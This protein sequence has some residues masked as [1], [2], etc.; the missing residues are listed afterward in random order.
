MERKKEID[1][2]VF[3]YSPAY[4]R[5]DSCCRCNLCVIIVKSTDGDDDEEE[6]EEDDKKRKKNA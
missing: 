6:D 3:D 1:A 5:D 4:I 2:R